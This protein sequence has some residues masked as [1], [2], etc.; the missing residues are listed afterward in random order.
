MSIVRVY[1]EWLAT[2]DGSNLRVYQQFTPARNMVLRAARTSLIIFNNPT[3]TAVTMKVYSNSG[4]APRSLIATSTN[5][6]L[7]A[8]LHT[9]NHALK[10]TYFEFNYLPLKADETYHMVLGISGYTGTTSAHIAWA[11]SYP[12]PAYTLNVDMT[13]PKLSISPFDLEII[14]ADL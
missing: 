8:D 6:Q 3:F 1:G 2:A 14:G 5:S 11:H 13:F 4:G 10:S 9:L 7:K 12:R